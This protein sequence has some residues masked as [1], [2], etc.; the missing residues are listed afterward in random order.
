MF[1]AA[2]Q[3]EQLVRALIEAGATVDARSSGGDTALLLACQYAPGAEVEAL[4]VVRRLLA[5]GASVN[6][7]GNFACTPLIVAAEHGDLPLVEFL[8]AAGADP[9][10]AD[11]EGATAAT[12]ARAQQHAEVAE[13]LES[14]APRRR[15]GK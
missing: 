8:L 9:D 13:L 11:E 12:L 10:A 5:A 14:Q 3:D 7:R 4:A 15:E 1:A 2:R 6:P